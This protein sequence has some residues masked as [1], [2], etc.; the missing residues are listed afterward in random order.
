MRRW[1]GVVFA[2]SAVVG[3]SG[4]TP[5][6]GGS[7]GLTI[8]SEGHPVIVL[9]WCEGGA[10]D[11]VAV[12]HEEE[13]SGASA[14]DASVGSPASSDISSSAV[15]V[16]DARFN[17]PPL[18]GKSA[19]FR[20]DEPSDGWTVEPKPFVMVPGI[21]YRAFGSTRDHAYSTDSVSFASDDIAKLKPGMVLIQQYDEKKDDSVDVLISQEEFDRRGQDPSQCA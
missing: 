5:A 20:I 6:V 10:P 18:D 15:E 14:A 3:V 11:G 17:A 1:I 13:P 4:C 21:E 19:S 7:A 2:F 9:A 16:N 12:Y 8:D